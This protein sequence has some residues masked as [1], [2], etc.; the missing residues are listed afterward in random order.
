MA[1][2]TRGVEC[3]SGG[4]DGSDSGYHEG[5]INRCYKQCT[6]PISI[7]IHELAGSD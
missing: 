3:N 6:I 4:F 1:K 2:D 5:G 7:G